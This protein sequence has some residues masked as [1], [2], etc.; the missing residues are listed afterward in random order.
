MCHFPSTDCSVFCLSETVSLENRGG[1]VVDRGMGVGRS[2]AGGS[3]EGGQACQL[4]VIP[5]RVCVEV[6]LI[7]HDWAN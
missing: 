2:R 3:A 4:V 7:A 5:I 1:G 6:S